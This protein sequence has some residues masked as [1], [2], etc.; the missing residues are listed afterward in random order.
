MISISTSSDSAFIAGG[1]EA[2]GKG[3]WGG[4]KGEILGLAMLAILGLH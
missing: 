2:G 4:I 1:R 3:G